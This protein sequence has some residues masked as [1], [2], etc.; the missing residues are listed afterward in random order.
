MH[1]GYDRLCFNCGEQ[2]SWNLH[3]PLHSSTRQ[4]RRQQLQS[5]VPAQLT[6]FQRFRLLVGKVYAAVRFMYYLRTCSFEGCQ[7]C[8]LS[9]MRPCVSRPSVSPQ[10]DKKK[11]LTFR[12]VAINSCE[13]RIAFTGVANWIGVFISAQQR[14]RWWL[15]QD[16]EIG[17]IFSSPLQ[18]MML[19]L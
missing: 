13:A 10:R 14:Q 19:Q 6:T 15:N 17:A 7:I 18:W 8:R 5:D 9:T 3:N 4:M 2:C 1:R 11:L 16:I 12:L